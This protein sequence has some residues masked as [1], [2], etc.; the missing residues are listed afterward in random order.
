M[1]TLL[2]F[3]ARFLC[4]HSSDYK[5][6]VEMTLVSGLRAVKFRCMRCDAFVWE[7]MERDSSE[8]L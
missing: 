8:G 5:E 7:Y 4:L 1:K 3:L 2:R 6:P